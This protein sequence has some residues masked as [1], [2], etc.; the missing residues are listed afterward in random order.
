VEARAVGVRVGAHYGPVVASRLGAE[1]HH[2]ITVSGD[3]VNVANRLMEVGKAWGAD[4]VASGDLLAAAGDRSASAFDE[5]RGVSIRG[6]VQPL[7]VAMRRVEP[8]SGSPA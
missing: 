3:S 7:D 1:T 2:Q 5:R 6:R 4:L 8:G